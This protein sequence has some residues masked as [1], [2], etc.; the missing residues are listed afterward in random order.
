[1]NGS[2][3]LEEDYRQP[4]HMCPVDFRKTLQVTSGDLHFVSH[5]KGLNK[6]FQKNGLEEEEKWTEKLITEVE[7][8]LAKK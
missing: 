8:A 1:M 2:G 7:T 6:F 4:L 3:N 5:F